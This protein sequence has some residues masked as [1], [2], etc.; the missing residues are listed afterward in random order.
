MDA[1]LGVVVLVGSGLTA[2]VL[3]SVALSVVPAF[4][5]VEPQRYVELHKLVGRRYDHVMPPMVVTWTLCDVVLAVAADTASGR[6]LFTLA[7][8][9]GCGVAA[10]SQLGNVPIN[11]R[12]KRMPAGPVPIGWADPRERW[13][14]FNLA[15][16]YLAVLA[17]AA[18]AYALLL[19]R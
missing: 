11:R 9:L 3:F 6:L 7:A 1:L 15:R 5:G 14:A 18:N 12:V 10:V 2:G 8:T 19:T 17:L 13:R 16:T 4:L